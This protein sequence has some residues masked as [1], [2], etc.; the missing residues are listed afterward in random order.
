MTRKKILVIN[1]NSNETVT[2]G[3]RESLTEFSDRADVHCC[4][5]DDGP[6]GIESDED[7]AQVI[8]L[9]K[10]RISTSPDYDAYVIACYSDPGLAQCCDLF[11]KPVFGLQKSAVETAVALGGRFGVLALSDE[12]IARHLVYVRNLGLED[13]LA[14]EVPLNIS[15][16]Q[17]A[18]DPETLQKVI[19]AGRMLVDE[20]DVN[21]LILGCAGMA[22]TKEAAEKKL[23]VPV[24]EPAQAAVCLAIESC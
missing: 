11:D 3:L 13:K 12:S 19:V 24:I 7:I 23:P 21:A 4:T 1:P 17:S 20:F 22:T 10:D 15:V 14:A 6:F 16:D 8:P 5:L 18:N 2:N 9:V